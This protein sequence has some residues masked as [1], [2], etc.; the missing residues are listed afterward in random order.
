MIRRSIACDIRANG[1]DPSLIDLSASSEYAVQ[2]GRYREILLHGEK[3][4]RNIAQ[5]A[6]FNHDPDQVIGSVVAAGVGAD[7]TVRAQIRLLDGARLPSGPLVSDAVKAGALRGVSIGYSIDKYERSEKD[8]HIEIRAT[9]WTLR[10]ISLTPIPADHTVGIGRSDDSEAFHRAIE[11]TTAAPAAQEERATMADPVTTEPQASATIL[12]TADAIRAEAKQIAGQAEAL[13]LRSAEFIGLSLTDARAAMLD[14]VAKTRAEKPAPQIEVR[15]EEGTKITEE[16]VAALVAGRSVH[17]VARRF[18]DRNGVRGV[19]SWGKR[20]STDFI[21]SRAVEISS[22]FAQVT[23]LAANKAMIGGYDSYTPWSDP[24]V[25]KMTTGDFKTVRVAGLQVGDFSEPGEGVAFSDLTIDDNLTGSGALTFRGAGLEL[26]KEAIYNDELGLF[27]R[28]LGQIGM[29]ARRHQDIKV[30]AAMEAANFANAALGT[31]A[32]AA[33]DLAAAWALFVGFT[34]PAGQKLGVTPK[35][36]VVPPALWNTAASLCTL[37]AGGA[38]VAGLA[39][40]ANPAIGSPLTPIVGLH[41]S[42]ANDWYL[43]ADPMQGG[44]FTVVTHTDYQTPQVFEVDSGLVASRKFRIEYPMA[45]ITATS[46]ANKP[47]GF[48]KATVA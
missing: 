7:K 27:L 47:V 10:E 40:L 24:I 39:G 35:Y 21:M 33:A 5:A 32:L 1:E 25:N 44:A 37:N 16:A 2:R 18:A 46:S 41:L 31:A 23:I 14:A 36:L 45:V 12:P 29:T 28:K 15:A 17:D 11:S 34:G 42:D 43:A 4:V 38:S 13:G 19:A 26:S 22:N 30:A 6:L 3:N 8:G 48:G 20:E 9:E